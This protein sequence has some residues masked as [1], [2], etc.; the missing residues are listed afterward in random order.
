MNKAAESALKD[1]LMTRSLQQNGTLK[2]CQS[3]RLM[4]PHLRILIQL[5]T[6]DKQNMT[7]KE[8]A[9]QRNLVST[10]AGVKQGYSN[11]SAF[12]HAND[13]DVTSP[14]KIKKAAVEL[15]KDILGKKKTK[16][17]ARKYDNTYSTS[18]SE[19][20]SNTDDSYLNLH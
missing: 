13:Y 20:F 5:A 18:F 11:A 15:C 16:K 3:T 19:L 1:I 10:K 9:H 7:N 6:S 8:R 2:K 17:I 12:L 14:K 4:L